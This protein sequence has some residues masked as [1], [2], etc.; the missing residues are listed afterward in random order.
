MATVTPNNPTGKL[1]VAPNYTERELADYKDKT[2]NWKRDEKP[3]MMN[4]VPDWDFQELLKQRDASRLAYEKGRDIH[5][6]S[7]QS[8]GYLPRQDPKLY[9]SQANRGSRNPSDKNYEDWQNGD[10]LGKKFDPKFINEISTPDGFKNTNDRRAQLG[11]PP[12]NMKN[13]L[14]VAL[15]PKTSLDVP[16]VAGLETPT[17]VPPA[18]PNTLPRTSPQLEAETLSAKERDQALKKS[19]ISSINQ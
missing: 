4:G 7:S 15:Q 3:P 13:P 10:G 18:L 12:L 19:I 16:Q 5:I 1:K 8:D 17:A 14:S 2:E 6:A 9:S 11:L